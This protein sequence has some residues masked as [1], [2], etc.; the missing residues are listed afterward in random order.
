M[1][2]GETLTRDGTGRL[3]LAE[4]AKP[5]GEGIDSLILERPRN[6]AVRRVALERSE[7]H[8]MR[9]HL[10][11]ISTYPLALLF[12]VGTV[13]ASTAAN[14]TSGAELYTADSYSYG[15]FEARIQFAGG[16]GVVSSFFLWKSGS[17]MSDVFWNELDLETIW[18][19]CELKTNALYGLPETNQT[20]SSGTEGG[21]CT[22]FH[23]Y[24]FEWTPDYV[25]WSVDGTELR[26]ETGADSAAFRDNA[27]AEGM[28]VHFNVWPGDSTFG[29]NFTEAILPVHEYINWVQYSSYADGVFTLDWREDFA[30]STLPDGWETGTWDSPKGLSTHMPENVSFVDGYA[31]ISLTTDAALGPAG[32]TPMDPEGGGPVDPP[33]GTG[34]SDGSDGAGGSGLASS[35][36]ASAPGS[37]GTPDSPGAGGTG[38][39]PPA[40]GAPSSGAG[41]SGTINPAS[42][43]NSTQ[44]PSGAGGDLGT[45]GPTGPSASG[46]GC[47]VGG[48]STPSGG[49]ILASALYAAG[50]FRR[51]QARG[52][53]VREAR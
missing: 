49:L 35:G 15:R 23:T 2:A 11:P 12:A 9:K 17:E 40:G 45:G 25:A 19:D 30:G 51:R 48:A 32:A 10:K 53:G 42:G 36:G 33:M 4:S 41:G 52:Y 34:G 13:S 18:A 6:R 43:G 1:G 5:P 26:R 28:Q 39:T 3:L 8:T 44:P 24:A 16:D 50:W 7:S 14:A 37:G 38:T 22:G 21:W 47:T 29:G 31:I 46:G 27:S 20:A